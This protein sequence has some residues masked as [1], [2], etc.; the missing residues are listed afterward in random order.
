MNT[1]WLTGA[2]SDR[3]RAALS[4][5]R[6]N[7]IA[8][9]SVSKETSHL[10]FSALVLAPTDD[11]SNFQEESD[12]GCYLVAE[13]AIKHR[14]FRELTPNT[15]PKIISI[16]TMVANSSLGA[17]ASDTYWRDN[18]A[19]LA[20][21][22]HEKMT[23]YYQLSVQHCFHGP[24]WDG[25]ALCSFATEND[26]RNRFFNSEAGKQAIAA[27]VAK[28]ADTTHSPRRVITKFLQPT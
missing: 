18:H 2:F 17:A 7:G 9:S 24:L 20:L 5:A 22:I 23:H 4:A 12:I 16:F 13:R 3:D 28:F 15:E 10:P 1:L 27:D 8:L 25:F 21:E 26:L 19:P 11:F 6:H 14:P